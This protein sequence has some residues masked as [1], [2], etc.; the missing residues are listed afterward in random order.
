MSGN[1]SEYLDQWQGLQIK[2]KLGKY[3]SEKEI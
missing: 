3:Q 1:R 2:R